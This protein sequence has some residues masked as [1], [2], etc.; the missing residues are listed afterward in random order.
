M[1]YK[2]QLENLQEKY[3]WMDEQYIEKYEQDGIFQEQ[4]QE[5]IKEIGNLNV[6][7]KGIEI[8]NKRTEYGFKTQEVNFVEG[9]TWILKGFAAVAFKDYKRIIKKK[10]TTRAGYKK[11]NW[12]P[13]ENV[14]TA[15]ISTHFTDSKFRDNVIEEKGIKRLKKN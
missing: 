15:I 8:D 1:D 7:L 14:R 2:K 11:K 12:E 10:G 3:P 4:E 9:T 6:L 13:S 5:E